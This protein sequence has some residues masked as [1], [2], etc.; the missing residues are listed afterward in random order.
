MVEVTRD[1]H[2]DPGGN[3][4][5]ATRLDSAEGDRARNIRNPEAIIADTDGWYRHKG[6][7]RRPGVVRGRTPR[8]R[9]KV[10][11]GNVV[12]VTNL[13]TDAAPRYYKVE[14][15]TK[16]SSSGSSEAAAAII[17]EQQATKQRLLE[18]AG[19]VGNQVD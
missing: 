4:T 14:R 1:Q 16:G 9:A 13:Y 3:V 17:A 6:H 10:A 5:K 12:K 15:K 19:I 18:R 8:T 7:R 2:L 11:G